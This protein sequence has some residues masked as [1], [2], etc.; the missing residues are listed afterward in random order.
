MKT[1]EIWYDFLQNRRYVLVRANALDIAEMI[2]YS[3]ETHRSL[4]FR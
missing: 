3:P 1:I 4:Y 2:K